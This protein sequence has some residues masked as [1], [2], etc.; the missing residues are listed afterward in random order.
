MT[1]LVLLGAAVPVAATYLLLQPARREGASRGLTTALAIGLGLGLSSCTFFV[2]LELC[3]G[4]RAGVAGIDALLLAA[5][6]VAWRRAGAAP[7]APSTPLSAREG[8]LVAAVLAAALAAAI[9]FLANTVQDP[10]GR[11]DAWATWNLRARWLA[12]A[13]PA[14]RDG[15][16]KPTIHGDYPLLLPGAVA[17]L[18][19]YGGGR[20]L[21]APAAVAAAYGAALILLLYAALSSLRDRTQGLIGALCL[22]GTPFLL[23]IVAWQYADVPLAFNLLAVV[24]LLALADHDPAGGRLLRLWAGVAAGLLAWSKNEGMVLVLGIVLVQGALMLA[25]R[26]PSPRG[27]AW[28]LA[29]LLPPAAVVLWFKLTLSPLSSQFHRQRATMLEQVA[30]LSRY[31]AIGRAAVSEL[32]RG[33][34][35]ILLALALYGILLG[36]TRDQRARRHATD[37]LAIVGFAAL[38]YGFTYLTSRVDLT[39]LLSYSMDR[40]LLQLWPCGLFAALLY[41]ASPREH[42]APEPARRSPAARPRLPA[43]RRRRSPTR[44]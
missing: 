6:L 2:A 33:V 12:E 31:E 32:I 14:W 41:L 43:P 9:S 44:P 20:D 3:D 8:L 19:V 18:W 5:A 10:H 38:A 36:R 35:A 7:A 4:G 40:L 39:W 22:L 15:F 30:D 24:A 11:W 42:D 27:A 17:R 26:A 37:A 1:G 13:G 23:R 29:G 28:F 25:R 16:A 21:V 34:G